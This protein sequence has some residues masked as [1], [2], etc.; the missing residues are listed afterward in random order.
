MAARV[1]QL[2]ADVLSSLRRGQLAE[3]ARLLSSS[4]DTSPELEVLASRLRRMGVQALE[5]I[6]S[7]ESLSALVPVVLF[8]SP[9]EEV[10]APASAALAMA[11]QRHVRAPSDA[12]TADDATGW[13]AALVPLLVER[14]IAGALFDTVLGLTETTADADVRTGA[15]LCLCAKWREIGYEGLSDERLARLAALLPEG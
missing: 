4:T 9:T 15:L 12:A 5:K 13:L 8:I 11:L 7:P 3:A 14:R 10:I 6:A 2:Q 1:D